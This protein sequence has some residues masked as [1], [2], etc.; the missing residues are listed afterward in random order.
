MSGPHLTPEQFQ[1]V[2]PQIAAWIRQTL[3]DHLS[4]A[5]TVAT[6]GFSRLPLYF[7]GK[8]L[9]T[10]NFVVVDQVPVPPLTSMGLSQFADFE[11]G[12]YAGITYLDTFFVRRDCVADEGLYF[13]ELI[14]VVQWQLLGP[15][16]FVAMYAD[17]LDKFGYRDSPLE[18]IAYNA[19]MLFRKPPA[20]PFNAET[21]VAEQLKLIPS[22]QAK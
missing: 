4:Q 11:A 17:G 8:H 9:A 21:L 14:H 18:V 15:E 3:I 19:E 10:S 1:T 13:H 20:K 7:S 16:R 5:K 2:Y 6:A 22:S 12:S